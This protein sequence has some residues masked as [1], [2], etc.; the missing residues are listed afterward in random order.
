MIFSFIIKKSTIK[1]IEIETAF[2]SFHWETE[3]SQVGLLLDTATWSVSSQG[4]QGYFGSKSANWLAI[5]IGNLVSNFFKPGTRL[6]L[7]VATSPE[8]SEFSSVQFIYFTNFMNTKEDTFTIKMYNTS[9]KKATAA[10]T[11]TPSSPLGDQESGRR[12]PSFSWFPNRK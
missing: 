8:W 12:L 6:R 7:P 10:P 2:F 4:L 11:P 3:G 5:E 9:R 1:A